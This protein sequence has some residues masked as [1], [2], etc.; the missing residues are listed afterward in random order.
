MGEHAAYVISAYAVVFA[1]V[2]GLVAL[3]LANRAA[4]VRDLSKAE[5]AAARLA[6][7]AADRGAPGGPS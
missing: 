4:A 3:V 6:R 2:V 7:S 5:R 1:V